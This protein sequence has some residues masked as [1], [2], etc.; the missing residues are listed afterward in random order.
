MT[1]SSRQTVVVDTFSFHSFASAG[2]FYC[3]ELSKAFDV[4]LL[5]AES[6]QDNPLVKTLVDHGRVVRVV[7]V[8]DW[9]R[10]GAAHRWWAR[11]FPALLAE[12]QPVMVFVS[13]VHYFHQKYIARASR[14]IP[15]LKI[16]CFLAVHVPVA[17][18]EA[19]DHHL[20][21]ARVAQWRARWPWL[22]RSVVRLMHDT[23]GRWVGLRDFALYPLL[24]TGQ[25]LTQTHCPWRGK[26]FSREVGHLFDAYLCYEPIERQNLFQEMPDDSP[27]I[28]VAHPMLTNPDAVEVL[29][30]DRPFSGA[31][32]ALPSRCAL[33]EPGVPD[34]H[35]VERLTDLWGRSLE[36]VRDKAGGGPILW[37]LHPSFVGDPVM[38]GVTSA[39]ARRLPDF[40]ALNGQMTAEQM[41]MQSA[42]VVGDVSTVL[43]WANRCR[44]KAV[45]SLAI[46]GLEDEDEMAHY[47]GI[48]VV[49]SVD[50]L[51]A[52]PAAELRGNGPARDAAP[53]VLETVRG[54]VRP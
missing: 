40:H 27:M 19:S 5:V 18:F 34:S 10:R 46:W 53:S 38:E 29:F 17:D 20:V 37:R 50:E 44:D 2:Y 36:I 47:P 9:K 28:L 14:R 7:S 22:P 12:C 48:R 6:D 23:W 21:E 35:T 13:N 4:V 16:V 39:L 43:L 11:R 15:H 41:M 51:Q 26:L 3:W 8:P 45:I 31:I 1:H 42:V 32:C 54:L 30:P 49:R 25:R 24:L 33:Y 52:I